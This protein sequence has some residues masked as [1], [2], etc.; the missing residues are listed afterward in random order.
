M[1]FERPAE[2]DESLTQLVFVSSV[3]ADASG[4]LERQIAAIV[5][6]LSPEFSCFPPAVVR[7]IGAKD[8]QHTQHQPEQAVDLRANRLGFGQEDAIGGDDGC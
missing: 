2:L 1:S 6:E 3:G 4:N 5:Q 7:G 8:K